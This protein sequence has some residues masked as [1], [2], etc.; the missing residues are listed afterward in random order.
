MPRCPAAEQGKGARH[1]IVRTHPV[2][3]RKALDLG[4]RRAAWIVGLPVPESEALLDKLWA[5]ATQPAFI[6]RHRW[7]VGDV[8][9]WD[10]RCL[11]HRRDAFDPSYRRIMLRLTV[12]GEKPV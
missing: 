7:R 8:L 12:R 3:R 2:N 1:P 6:W 11:I 10:N 4:R 5:H 9:V